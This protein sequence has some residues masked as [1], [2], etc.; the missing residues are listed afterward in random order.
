MIIAEP[1]LIK[2]LLIISLVKDLNSAPVT[3]MAEKILAKVTAVDHSFVSR[4]VSQFNMVSYPGVSDVLVLATPVS[5]LQLPTTLTGLTVLLT[6][7]QPQ[8][9]P[10]QQ[11]KNPRQQQLN[12]QPNQLQLLQPQVEFEI[13]IIYN[14][15]IKFF[16]LEPTQKKHSRRN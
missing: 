2:L 5:M 8:L 9:Q 3:L 1:M 10:R 14:F 15:S 11:H 12:Q 4:M 6:H 16:Y 7:H 13:D